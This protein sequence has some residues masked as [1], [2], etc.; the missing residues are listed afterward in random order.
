ME[1]FVF[2]VN[3][4]VNTHD[5]WACIQTSVDHWN[6]FY[7]YSYHHHNSDN[8]SKK[9]VISTQSFKLLEATCM[10]Y[11]SKLAFKSANNE[12]SISAI[13]FLNSYCI[14]VDTIKKELE[15]EFIKSCMFYLNKA[16]T[17]LDSDPATSFIIL[18]RRLL[19][20]KNHITRSRQY[21]YRQILDDS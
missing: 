20:L 4:R 21:E 19:L 8:C 17:N 14:Q 2:V 16:C 1:S 5:K 13:Q 7:K 3:I 11:I 15:V 12:V 6:S 10:D 9:S 18:K